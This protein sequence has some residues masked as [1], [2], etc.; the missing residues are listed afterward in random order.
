MRVITVGKKRSRGVQLI[1]DEYKDKLQHYC[2]I[3]DVLVRSNP[4]MPG[5]LS[6]LLRFFLHIVRYNGGNVN[7]L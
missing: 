4:K 5:I 3:D 7:D 1:V 6:L 2:A